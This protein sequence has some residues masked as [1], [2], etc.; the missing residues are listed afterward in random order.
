MHMSLHSDLSGPELIFMDG[1]LND[2][3]TVFLL[4]ELKCHLQVSFTLV[5][6]QGQVDGNQFCFALLY[7][8]WECKN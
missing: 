8:N 7:E 5:K 1:F 4:S 2:F 6:A 3:C